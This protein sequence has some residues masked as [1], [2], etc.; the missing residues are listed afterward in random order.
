M[1]GTGERRDL[2]EKERR[3]RL[4]G[5]GSNLK[6]TT[7][8]TNTSNG[9]QETNAYLRST[10]LEL[11]SVAS[12]HRLVR[13]HFGLNTP[14]AEH[15]PSLEVVCDCRTHREQA[16]VDGDF[17]VVLDWT[18]SGHAV[19][20]VELISGRT[21]TGTSDD[22]DESRRGHQRIDHFTK[23][24]AWFFYASEGSGRSKKVHGKLSAYFKRFG[25]GAVRRPGKQ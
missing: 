20:E 6:N 17:D 22:E 19:S 18:C 9:N 10:F 5:G 11:N 12:I 23:E 1:G 8:A 16:T 4:G 13:T 24:Y 21:G 7:T 3:E 2:V 25:H 15:D 14:G